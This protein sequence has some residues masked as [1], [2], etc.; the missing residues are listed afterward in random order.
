M[1]RINDVV[2]RERIDCSAIIVNFNGGQD[3][4]DCLASLQRQR[5]VGIE[6]IIVDNGSSDGSLESAM[7]AYPS[8]QV[9]RSPTNAGFAGG[10]NRGAGMAAGDVLLFLNP[11]VVLHDTCVS[12]LC[13]RLR[14]QPGVAGPRLFVDKAGQWEY[15][16]VLDVVGFPVALD[17]PSR[18]LYVPG[19][20]LATG[21]ETFSLLGGFDERYFMICE[22][23]DYCWRALLAGQAVTV[24]PQSETRHKGAGSTPGGY[25]HSGRR[26]VSSFRIPLHERNRLAT[27][28]KCA[29]LSWLAVAAPGCVISTV[30]ITLGAVAMGR[31]SLARALLRGL[32]WN[33]QELPA[34]MEARRNSPRTI[35]RGEATRGRIY[36]GIYM[37][38]SLRRHGLP[39]FV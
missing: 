31:W 12:E 38:K 20:A 13:A 29:S 33:F 37:L 14:A 15:G 6:T 17:R 5:D 7:T 16:L 30:A 35:P 23:A 32:F 11:D 28:L 24:V 10:A 25:V 19:C 34:T 36:P 18:P 1:L 2:Q 9:F 8:I 22:D 21:R 3:L 26:D 39:R 4:I 27:V